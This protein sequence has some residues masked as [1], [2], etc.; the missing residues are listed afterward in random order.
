MQISAVVCLLAAH[1]AVG[2]AFPPPRTCQI[3]ETDPKPDWN[4][5]PRAVIDL[6][7]AAADRWTALATAY[8]TQVAAMVNEFVDHLTAMP[9]DRWEVRKS[10]C[11]C[12]CYL[13][14]IFLALIMYS[15]LDLFIDLFIYYL[16][17]A[18]QSFI[19]YLDENQDMVLDRMPNGNNAD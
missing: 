9:G 5:I 1:F 4:S 7:Q 2:S 10:Y 17:H 18:P 8:S 19:T 16:S 3:S 6:D 13:Y 15:A 14:F 12:Y 11:Y